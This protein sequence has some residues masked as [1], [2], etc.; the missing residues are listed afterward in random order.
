MRT[1]MTNLAA[2]ALVG[3]CAALS[4]VAQPMVAVEFPVPESVRK[5]DWRDAFHF[6]PWAMTS[7]A[8]QV[9]ASCFRGSI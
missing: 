5:R 9:S 7:Q 8:D 1:G 3:C 6:R 4:A 2:L